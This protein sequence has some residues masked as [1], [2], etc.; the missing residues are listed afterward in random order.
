ME[1][2]IMA[3]STL[4][5]ITTSSGFTVQ[6]D[7]AIG[8]DMEIIDELQGLVTGKGNAS[9]REIVTMMIG[10]EAK[11]AMYEHCRVNGR[12]SAKKIGEELQDIMNA[13]VEMLKKV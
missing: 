8:D 9:P 11:N 5:E 2:H 4:K 3:K 10:E 7:P 6:I 13:A 12:V 1:V